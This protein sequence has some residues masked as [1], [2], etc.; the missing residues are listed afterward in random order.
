MSASNLRGPGSAAGRNHPTISG[1]A[2]VLPAT[3]P[4]I[5]A[6][7]SGVLVHGTYWS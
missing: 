1:V 6:D 3:P 2:S 5:A 7:E 4:V